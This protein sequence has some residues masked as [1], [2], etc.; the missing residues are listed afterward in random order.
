MQC[1]EDNKNDFDER[2]DYSQV[3]RVRSSIERQE[4]N[5]RKD[6]I[7]ETIQKKKQDIIDGDKE[8]GTKRQQGNSILTNSKETLR[9]KIDIGKERNMMKKEKERYNNNDSLEK[10]VNKEEKDNSFKKSNSLKEEID[11]RIKSIERT[12]IYTQGNGLAELAK[13]IEI[14][15]S[16]IDIDR[17][18]DITVLNNTELSDNEKTNRHTRNTICHKCKQYGHTKKQCDIHNKIVKQINKLEFEKVVINE[19]MEMFDVKQKEIDQV[20]KKEELKSTNPLKV[21]KRK[22][23]QKT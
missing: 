19:L 20:K 8:R 2:K 4:D 22:M 6:D 23:K 5:N 11:E 17:K 1:K 21:N 9:K 14:L 18:R 15:N 12:M 16:P 13:K 3:V 10:V 7:I